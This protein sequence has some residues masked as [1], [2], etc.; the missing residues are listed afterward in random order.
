MM[1]RE[2]HL[3]I[4][5]EVY[6]NN[7][8]YNFEKDVKAERFARKLLDKIEDSYQEGNYHRE[9]ENFA[10][11]IRSHHADNDAYW[12]YNDGDY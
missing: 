11:Y 12:L 5:R 4:V 10:D 9:Y 3:Q 6:V 8:E 7:G 1:D 2:K